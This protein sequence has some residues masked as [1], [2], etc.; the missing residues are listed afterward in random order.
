MKKNL[1]FEDLPPKLQRY[2][3]KE[4]REERKKEY[5]ETDEEVKNISDEEI[6]KEYASNI[7]VARPIMQRALKQAEK[8]CKAYL[9]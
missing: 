6:K 3:M 2:F 8:D 9:S 5:V 1:L 4:A 7:T